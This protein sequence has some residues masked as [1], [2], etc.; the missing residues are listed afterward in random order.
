MTIEG[1][2]DRPPFPIE[3]KG[4]SISFGSTG[5]G[6]IWVPTVEIS[7]ETLIINKDFKK[8]FFV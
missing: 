6:F 3:G 8:D 7:C 5:Q 2:A 1:L 4:F